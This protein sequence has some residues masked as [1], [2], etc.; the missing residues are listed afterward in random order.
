[1]A[2]RSSF[3]TATIG[4]A[5]R[6]CTAWFNRAMSERDDD[7]ERTDAEAAFGGELPA[8]GADAFGD[9]SA[10]PPP[11]PPRPS[12]FAPPVAP[13]PTFTAPPAFTGAPAAPATTGTSGKAI[14][15]FVLSL[16][17]WIVCPVVAA[18][19]AI[20]LGH[21][22]KAEIDANPALGGRGLAQ[23]GFVLGIVG[24]AVYVLF[25]AFVVIVGGTS[26]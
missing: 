1:M 24:L 7:A 14:A 23:A 3:T 2:V 6:V 22:A 10:V 26:D 12:G 19:A 5:T 11:P 4:K 16:L 18:I 25:I 8:S 21:Q 20:F 15:A 13:Q 17:G 9:A